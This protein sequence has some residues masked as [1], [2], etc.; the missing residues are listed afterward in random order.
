MANRMK[1]L[2]STTAGNTPPIGSAADFGRLAFNLA[3]RKMWLYGST[4]TP[5]LLAAYTG[6]HVATSAYRIGDLAVH[7]AVLY[8]CRANISPKAFASA[9]WDV[10]GDFREQLLYRLPTIAAQARMTMG[11]ATVGAR[12]RAHASQSAALMAWENGAGLAVADIRSDGYPGAAFGRLVFRV[13][14]VAHG[15][16]AVGQPARF[17]GTNWVLANANTAAGKATAVVKEVIDANAVE[18]QIGGQIEGLQTSAFAGGVISPNTVYY[19]STSTPGLLT[20]T[21]PPDAEKIN[22]VLRTLTNASAV[23]N[24]ISAPI[25]ASGGGGGTDGTTA[26]VTQNPNPFTAVGQVAAFDGSAW[27]LADPASAT[28]TP[29]GVIAATAGFDFTVQFAG[30]ISDIAAGAAVAHPLSAGSTYYCND[31]GLLTTVAPTSAIM[32]SAP[33]LLALSGT[34]GVVLQGL[35]S[36]NALRASQNLADLTNAATAR[37]NLGL[38]NTV[39]NTRAVNTGTGLTGGGNLTVDRQIALN[40]ASIASLAKA[41]TAVQP[42]RAVNTGAGLTGG[43][44]LSVDRSLSLT[45]Q[46]LAIHQFANLGFILRTGAATFATREMAAGDGIT[47]TNATGLAGNPMFAVNASVVRTARSILPGVGLTGGGTLA[48]DRTLNVKE[49]ILSVWQAG[50]SDEVAGI[51]P[52]LLKQ[53]VEDQIPPSPSGVGEIGTYAFLANLTGTSSD[54]GATEPGS[55]LRYFGIR[56][57]QI[58]GAGN[59]YGDAPPGTWRCMG[60]GNASAGGNSSGTLWKRIS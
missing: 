22:P 55:N 30:E 53:T 51:S 8:R 1:F 29:L 21:P 40:A 42:A 23:L 37:G 33:V 43:G 7:G 19:T 57:T 9:D 5:H 17:D 58:G 50:I 34:T 11:V 2:R 56:D 52:L 14:Q 49:H 10:V 59:I 36:N 6:D 24:I 54:P 31:A 28:K 16:T 46:A 47:I 41:D 26:L 25:G 15:F 38:A 48:A 35:G 27:V 4:G 13:A 12:F 39:P 3:D 60:A 32:G 18:L 45:G 44:D 20:S